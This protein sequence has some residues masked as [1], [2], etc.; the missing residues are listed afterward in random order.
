ML[1]DIDWHKV[2][3]PSLAGL[4]PHELSDLHAAITAHA[5]RAIRVSDPTDEKQLP[6][7]TKPVEWFSRGFL[8]EIGKRPGGYLNYPAGDYYIQD[9]GSML[10]LALCEIQPGQV[11]LDA[12]S[13]PGGKS[14]GLLEQLDGTGFL[15]ANEVIK[16]RVAVLQD[17][18]SNQGYDNYVVANSDLEDMSAKCESV[19]DCVLVD[20]PCTGQS[21]LA[22]GKQTLAAFSPG[23]IE[24]SSQRQA[25]ILNAA[26]RLVRPGGR[27]VYSTC[28]FSWAE[29]EAII[30][31]FKCAH[32]HF[33]SIS[34]PDLAR[35]ESESERGCYR[36]WPHRH[37]TSGSFAAA[38]IKLDEDSKIE[39][40]VLRQNKAKPKLVQQSAIDLPV[41][42]LPQHRLVRR[43]D[44]IYLLS[45]KLSEASFA[46][47][48]VGIPIAKEKS[49]RWEPLHALARLRSLEVA[50]GPHA[51]L[52]DSEACLYVEGQS[53]RQTGLKT[54]GWHVMTW[55]GR[56]LGWGKVS[57]GVVKNHFPKSIRQ[58]AVVVETD[59]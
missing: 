37:P 18:L 45:D 24:H 4:E 49:K 7:A 54:K 8:V 51:S 43:K 12:C 39:W 27:L 40:P 32:P 56:K 30:S 9:A 38:L 22:K 29:N 31:D 16:S 58:P 20:A 41:A 28:S 2:L 21:M 10:A 15:V 50:S 6:F 33:K 11:V 1:T 36:L 14:T 48:F 19:F 52:L 59:G 3:G 5:P 55:S 17:A 23:Q 46:F 57:N 44:S 53:I 25:R 42:L 13:A 34:N 26:S 47:E 35:W